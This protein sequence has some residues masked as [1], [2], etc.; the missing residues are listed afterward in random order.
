MQIVL[1]LGHGYAMIEV[2]IAPQAAI[3]ST[4]ASQELGNKGDL[5]AINR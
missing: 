2:C 1:G 3:R 5:Y 4:A